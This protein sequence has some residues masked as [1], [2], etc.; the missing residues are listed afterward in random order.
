MPAHSKHSLPSRIIHKTDLFN[1]PCRLFLQGK[2]KLST[3]LG[4]SLTIILII[5]IIYQ[6][7]SKAAKMFQRKDPNIFETSELE[8][9][10][11]LMEFSPLSNFVFAVTISVNE[12]VRNLSESSPLNFRTTY[13]KYTRYLNGTKTK[14]KYLV[15]WASC[16]SS[17][18]PKE[19]YGANTFIVNSLNYAYCMT[20]I[21]M[22]DQASGVCDPEIE[23]KYPGCI[24]PLKFGIQGGYFSPEFDFL[25]SNLV[26]C[27]SADE[28]LP[29]GMKCTTEDVNEMFLTSSFKYNIFY[30]Y[31]LLNPYNYTT[32][33]KTFLENAYWNINPQI[34]KVADILVDRVTVQD[35]NS[36]IWSAKYV[37][38]TLYSIPV[39][40]V[41]EHERIRSTSSEVILQ[42]NLRRS[43]LNQAISRNYL[44]I[45]EILT[46]LGGFA[47]TIMFLAAFL[48]IGYVRYKYPMMIA[49]ELYDFDIKQE[50]E[51]VKRDTN[52]MLVG[53]H[54]DARGEAPSPYG[55]SFASSRGFG[56]KNIREYAERLKERKKRLVH[57]EGSY[58]REMFDCVCPRRDPRVSMANK[59]RKCASKDLDIMLIVRKLQ[60]FERLKRL[61]LTEVQQEAFEFIEKPCVRLPKEGDIVSS[62][63]AR[64]ESRRLENLTNKF[65]K[66]TKKNAD[67][68]SCVNLMK[69]DGE[70]IDM[71]NLENYGELYVAYKHIQKDRITENRLHN[72][73]LMGM[74]NPELV[75]VFNRVDQL[76]DEDEPTV[77][78]Y[79]YI[80]QQILKM[81]E[82]W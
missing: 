42:W 60:E 74:V 48:A 34:S 59:A 1:E 14:K 72:R 28:T 62:P 23:G 24:T 78:Q 58:L 71:G 51:V 35:F 54:S 10:P 70:E 25:Q 18:F 29:F 38:R 77:K 56:D 82:D 66:I 19:L 57:T 2:Q 17:D 52:F 20:G 5:F 33:N 43:N 9:N 55:H 41:R 26:V 6:I 45:T 39:S 49:N 47:K 64:R 50:E 73:K 13:S 36:F 79:V 75:K 63:Q 32:P 8:E 31:S 69:D 37:N 65:H 21:N 11:I 40:K 30:S 81:N 80:V 76:L 67:F 44:R 3:T 12:T 22:T 46:D 61:F 7:G 27:D 16:N 68:E 15:Q 4:G 53:D